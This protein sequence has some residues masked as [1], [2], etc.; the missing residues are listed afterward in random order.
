MWY[1]ESCD[2][3]S[4]N[5]FFAN[6]GYHPNFTLHPDRDL[7]SSCARNIVVDLNE[8]HQELK[9]TIAEA[10]CHYQ[11]PADSRRM[12]PP[13]FSIGQQAF[14]KAKFFRTTWPSKKL[15]ERF[16]GPFKILAQSGSHS[17]T[18]RLPDT[19]QGVH[20]IFHVS[21][22][23]PATP[24]N[25]PN[26]TVSP[27]PPIQVQGELEYEIAEVLDS[28]LDPASYYTTSGG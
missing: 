14:V 9:V 8:L 10:Q 22:L 25:I 23:E 12:P 1:E 7:A 6:K 2:Y 18:L 24:N 17:Y 5:T 15:S 11:G 27:P 20:P 4:F 19:I 13:T 21:M 3:Y 28:K 26:R 16:L